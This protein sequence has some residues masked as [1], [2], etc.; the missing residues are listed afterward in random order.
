MCAF[1]GVPKRKREGGERVADKCGRGQCPESQ[2][3]VK[4]S[5]SNP[6]DHIGP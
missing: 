3:S 2:G 1:G 4:G 6:F 5:Q